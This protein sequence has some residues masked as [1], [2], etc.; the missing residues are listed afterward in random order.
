MNRT[1]SQAI[2]LGHSPDPD[3]AFM[4]WPL[5]AGKVDSGSWRVVHLLEDIESL[6]RRAMMGEL[7]ITAVS[8]HAYAYLAD[9][10]LLLPHGASMGD[11]YGPLLVSRE[12]MT[13][14]DLAGATIAVPGRMTSAF[15][16]LKLYRPN[17]REIVVPFDEIPRYVADGKAPVGLLI[18]EGQLTYGNLG[19]H[20]VA[21]LGAWWK[22]ETGLPLP[23]G[24]NAIRRDLGPEAIRELSTILKSSIRYALDHREEAL[25]AAMKYA[26]DMGRDLADRFVGMYVNDYTLD[27]GPKG[28]E[29]IALFLDRA[30]QAGLVPP[31]GVEWAE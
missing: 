19:L 9:R 1:V 14:A 21:D 24:G 30:R 10:Y 3:D 17:V 13:P 16:A 5:A 4:W 8:I 27:Y 31:V 20:K 2:R 28:R 11:G 29:A 6:N 18:H 26:R 23:L 25:G 12:P 15:L 7:E 22:E